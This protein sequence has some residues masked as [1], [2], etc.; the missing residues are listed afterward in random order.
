MTEA[1]TEAHLTEENGR[2]QVPE[3]VREPFVV[4][5]PALSREAVGEVHIELPVAEAKFPYYLVVLVV[6]LPVCCLSG[7]GFGL[8]MGWEIWPVEYNLD[9]YRSAHPENLREDYRRAYVEA[10]SDRF[11]YDSDGEAVVRGLGGEAN[12]VGWVCTMMN[13]TAAGGNAPE[14][15]R[16]YALTYILGGCEVANE[17]TATGE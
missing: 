2:Q 7:L 9:E 8:F 5:N 11:A 6:F 13:E 17:P 4:E 12:M 15:I 3:M 14:T 1:I 10:H 16:L